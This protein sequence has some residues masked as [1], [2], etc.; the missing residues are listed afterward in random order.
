MRNIMLVLLAV[1]VAVPLAAEEKPLQVLT[2]RPD[3]NIQFQ[4]M[5]TTDQLLISVTDAAGHP[6]RGLTPADFII[7]QAGKKARILSAEPLETSKQIGLNLVFVIDNSASMKK[8]NAVRPLLEAMEAF[9][10]TVRP[11]DNI[12]L[13]TFSTEDKIQIDNLTLNTQT[14][15][16]A[17]PTQLRNF[18]QKSYGSGMSGR[19]VLYEAMVHG[20]KL[21]QAMPAKE[22]KFMVVFSDGEDINSA[23]KEKTVKAEAAMVDNMVSY[24][25]DY[26]PGAE[27]SP[28]LKEFTELNNGRVWKATS[29]AELLPVFESFSSTLLYRYVVAYRFL[30]PPRGTMTMLPTGLTLQR[31]TLLD[32]RPV[33][34]MVFF[35]PGQSALAAPYVLFNDPSQTATF[36]PD[37]Q[38][39]LLDR[40]HHILNHIG[41][42]LKQDTGLNAH[43]VGCRADE[44]I[45]KQDPALANQRAAAIRTYLNTIWEIDEARLTIEARKLPAKAADQARIGGTAENRRAEI[46]LKSA[47][48]QPAANISFVAATDTAEIVIRPQIEAEYGV[49]DWRIDLKTDEQI[50]KTLTGQKALQPE[51]RIALADLQLADWVGRNQYHARIRVADINAD[52]LETA[53]DMLPIQTRDTVL[54]HTLAGS[55]T[56]SVA[57]TPQQIVVEELTTIDSSPLLNFIFFETG[58]SELAP[59]YIQLESKAATKAFA[60]ARLKGTMEKYQNLLNIIGKRLR[61]NPDARIRIVGCNSGH[62]PEK[63]RTDL[64]RSRAEAVKAYLKYIWGISTGRMDVEARS[65]PAASST[66]RIEEG[67][68]E[69]QRVELYSETPAVLDT[70]QSTYVQQISKQDSLRVTPAI[71][72]DYAITAWRLDVTGDDKLLTSLDGEGALAP[73]YRLNFD[74]IDIAA[75]GASRTV[76]ATLQV[77]DRQGNMFRTPTAAVDVKYIKRR[78]LLAQKQGYKVQEK[79]ALILFDYNSAKIKARNKVIVDR[80]IERLKKFPDAE[81]KIVGH[82]DSIGKPEYNIALSEKRARAV[83]QQL[84]AAGM[85]QSDKITHAGIGANEPLYDNTR[86]EGRALNRTV[87]VELQYQQ[88]Q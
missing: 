31:L 46:D 36:R 17:D 33:T 61:D 74:Q 54:I 3:S 70:I 79:Y 20:L 8:R 77:T 27:P 81:V 35:K 58:A 9:F 40:Y 37:A 85:V 13:I 23:F 26:L 7:E 63:G 2:S 87:T 44:G 80:I 83:Y 52:S 18:L 48:M 14:I 12:H 11:I 64:S 62:G 53:T 50:V 41:W 21:M 51:Y 45:E 42:R 65:L 10:K 88:M 66:N 1:A 78:Q 16:S 71:S 25:I 86:P 76:G 19:T 55:P 38:V 24:A 57:V 82:S 4:T 69:N 15:K 56:G 6:M 84:L 30:N 47:G 29:A 32:G 5:E 59:Q 72:A 43:I 49:A 67:R 60:E 28:F 73:Q 68:R 75:V 34:N 22:H 39:A